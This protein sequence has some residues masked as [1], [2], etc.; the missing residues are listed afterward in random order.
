METIENK[1]FTNE[2]LTAA[3]GNDSLMKEYVMRICNAVMFSFGYNKK[4]AEYCDEVKA[5]A[6]E[7][8]MG[9]LKDYSSD[10]NGILFSYIK[11]RLKYKIVAEH[12]KLN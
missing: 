10:K 1:Y 3:L 6:V 4:H 7:F 8:T 11:N 5:S 2:T 9:K 12:K